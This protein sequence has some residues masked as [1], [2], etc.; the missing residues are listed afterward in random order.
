MTPR[1]RT[2]TVA[3]IAF[4]LFATIGFGLCTSVRANEQTRQVQEELRKRHLFYSDIDGQ[5]T[6]NL[7]TALE[8]Y[9]ERQHFAVT[10]VA[11]DETLLSLGIQSAAPPAD[12]PVLPDVPVLRSDT[13]VREGSHP[14]AEPVPAATPPP[15]AAA[16]LGP[17]TRKQ[18]RDFLRRYFDACQSPN[19]SDEIGFYAERVD[20]FDHGPVDKTYIQNEN[21]VYN[22]RWPNRRYTLGDSVRLTKEKE[23]TVAKCRISFAVANPL[24]NRAAS[25]KTDNTFGIARRPDGNFELVSIHEARVRQPS[26]GP[27][28]ANPVPRVLRRVHHVLRSIF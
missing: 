26:R 6:P 21:V 16:K 19:P 12:G 25:G 23:T 1:A 15:L 28:F 18:V 10:G 11:D 22:Q 8:R 20:Y 13:G 3:K 7:T 2:I 27:T 9:Q 17:V 4:V 5:V 14:F 24:R